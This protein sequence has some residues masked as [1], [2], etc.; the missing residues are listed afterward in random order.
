[1]EEGGWRREQTG[2][3]PSTIRHPPSVSLSLPY[4]PDI[5]IFDFF[6]G[7]GCFPEK[8]QAG[9]EGG[10]KKKTADRDAPPQFLP[11]QLFHQPVQDR[12]KRHPVQR[13][14][15]ILMRHLVPP[16]DRLW[17]GSVPPDQ[18]IRS[19]AEKRSALRAA[20]S[21]YYALGCKTVV[22][23]IGLRENAV[24][25]DRRAPAAT[26]RKEDLKNRSV[27][28]NPAAS[29]VSGARPPSYSRV[30]HPSRIR[31]LAFDT[32]PRLGG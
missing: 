7:P 20:E 22:T 3:P 32:K 5:K 28:L 19:V 16:A 1:M 21:P 2:F 23:F 13:I 26:V 31:I 17:P 18:G 12:F 30:P 9:G 24:F 27:L 14:F 15:Q 25:S 10:I 8:P 11:T 6:P 4:H 29:S